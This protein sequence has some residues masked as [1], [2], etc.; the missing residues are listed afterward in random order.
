MSLSLGRRS[1][2]GARIFGALADQHQRFGVFQASGQR[3]DLLDVIV[4]DLDL[5]TGQLAKAFSVRS[6]S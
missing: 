2:R 5:V 4:P 3:I 6:V 1:S